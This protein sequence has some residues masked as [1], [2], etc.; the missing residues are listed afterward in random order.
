[1]ARI[2]HQDRVEKL[3]DHFRQRGYL[4]L[5]RRFGKYLPEPEPVGNYEVDAIGKYKKKVA[6][7]ITL[8]ENDMDDPK[9]YSKLS[10]LSTKY[11]H[12]QTRRVM[13]FV[14]VPKPLIGKAR[15]II[16][17]LDEEA[18]KR[19]KLVAINNPVDSHQ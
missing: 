7:G 16:A 1:M 17:A 6:I 19:I 12:L 2:T 11:A 18:K 9:I 5:S 4:T 13:L 8:T 15:N 10:F 14:G 3:I